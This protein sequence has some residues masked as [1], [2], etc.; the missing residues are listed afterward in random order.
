MKNKSEDAGQVRTCDFHSSNCWVFTEKKTS[1]YFKAPCRLLQKYGVNLEHSGN[2]QVCSPAGFVQLSPGCS[3]VPLFSQASEFLGVCG[4]AGT[5]WQ[6]SPCPP[7][8]ELEPD[9]VF[10]TICFPDFRHNHLGDHGAKLEV[11]ISGTGVINRSR[12]GTKIL[13]KWGK[14]AL[15]NTVLL[16]LVR[17]Y[18]SLGPE[19]RGWQSSSLHSN[20]DAK[21]FHLFMRF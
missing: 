1:R 8:S 7:G 19:V 15:C 14:I 16:E 11:A 13:P 10:R 4:S 21:P 6:S 18:F 3:F 2:I 20:A 12:D 17:H 9:E 5:V